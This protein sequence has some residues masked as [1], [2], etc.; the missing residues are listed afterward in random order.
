MPDKRKNKSKKHI[1]TKKLK[2]TNKKILA[3]GP[4]VI[5]KHTLKRLQPKVYVSQTLMN[6]KKQ[7]QK[8][9]IRLAKKNQMLMDINKAKKNQDLEL[10]DLKT[11]YKDASFLLDNKKSGLSETHP[12]IN[13]LETELEKVKEDKANVEKE[14]LKARNTIVQKDA[15]IELLQKPE[16]EYKGI[17]SLDLERIKS[18]WVGWPEG[19]NLEEIDFVLVN[20]SNEE[21]KHV[22]ADIYI[23]DEYNNHYKCEGIKVSSLLEPK[24]RISKKI[25]LFKQLKNRGKYKVEL[26]IFMKGHDKEIAEQTKIL[27]I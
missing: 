18:K 8:A 7:L 22:F 4:V 16:Y 11:K 15:I 21:I 12:S 23:S 2:Q 14:Y 6:I 13:Q 17:V 27:I 10:E 24:G 25:H 20:N 3:S 19:S 26:R 1:S 5:P 9:E